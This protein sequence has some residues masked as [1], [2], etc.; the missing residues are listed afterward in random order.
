MIALS[1]W[2]RHEGAQF[3]KVQYL[4]L[5]KCAIKF[6]IVLLG[7]FFHHI[8]AHEYFDAKFCVNESQAASKY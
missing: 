7:T 4:D 2:D 8:F 3:H 6:L 1:G 5:I